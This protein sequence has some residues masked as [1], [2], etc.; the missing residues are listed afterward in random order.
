MKLRVLP[1]LAVATFTLAGCA[2]KVDYAKFN[3]KAK[4][5]AEKAK[6]VSFSKVVLKGYY[7]EDGKKEDYDGVEIKFEKG[8]FLPKS[9][10]SVSEAYA[11][12][13]SAA[14][15]LNFYVASA[16]PEDKD[17]TYYAGSTFKI[18]SVDDDDKVTAQWNKY[19][20]LTSIKDKDSK[21]TVKYSK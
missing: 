8:T 5:A 12:E 1:L 3:E 17:T 15:L 9:G 4:A 6:D 11:K 19:G 14:F 18:V 16:I 13:V 7:T 20:L 21:I 10:V 2:A